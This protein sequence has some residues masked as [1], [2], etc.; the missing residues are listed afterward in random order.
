MGKGAN[1]MKVVTELLLDMEEAAAVTNRQSR[2]KQLDGLRKVVIS[3]DHG[4]DRQLEHLSGD[5]RDNERPTPVSEKSG[6]DFIEDHW[7]ASIRV[8]FGL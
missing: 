8:C 3:Q 4:Q 7:D 2:L 1:K 6:R 5:L